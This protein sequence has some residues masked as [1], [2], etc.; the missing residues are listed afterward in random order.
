MDGKN[1][2]KVSI[3]ILLRRLVAEGEAVGVVANG[4]HSCE[5]LQVK[6]QLACKQS[7]DR[8]LNSVSWSHSTSNY[9]P[10]KFH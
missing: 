10:F 6:V 8:C 1:G 5:V 2:G 9:P 4:A 3:T 7:F